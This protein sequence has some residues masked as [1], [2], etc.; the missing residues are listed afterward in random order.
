MI[1]TVTSQQCGDDRSKLSV[2][3]VQTNPAFDL[4]YLQSTLMQDSVT[5]RLETGYQEFK[6]ALK[7]ITKQKIKVIK[8]SQ[9][10][11]SF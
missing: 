11:L 2:H 5:H 8:Y 10:W 3:F 7:E 9:H 4:P 6:F 1:S